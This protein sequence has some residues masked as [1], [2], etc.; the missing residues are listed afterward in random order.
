MAVAAEDDTMNGVRKPSRPWPKDF[1]KVTRFTTFD[2]LKGLADYADAKAG[3]WKSAAN[4]IYEMFAGKTG[5]WQKKLVALAGKHPGAILL[6]VHAEEKTGRNQ[7]PN[8]FAAFIAELTGLDI[9]YNIVQSERAG[10][11]GAGKWERMILRPK[12][13]GE[14]VRGG[15][16]ILVDDVLT[17]GGTF[18]E[19]RRYIEAMGGEVVDIV[20]LAGEPESAD[21]ALSEETKNRLE[22]V[23]G[24]ESLRE[25]LS[26]VGLYDGEYGALTEAEA[27]AL[28]EAGTFD[29]A[30]NRIAEAE[31]AREYNG[32]P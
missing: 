26:E 10:R 31:Q 2:K 14:V 29:E 16:Y 11:T 23:F 3:D 19:L 15:K 7:I 25:F 27:N 1:P 32:G 24:V 22:Q 17:M 18:S 8:Q 28:L 20:A 12:F 9:D 4:L 5:K 21:I 30:R 6:S 13:D